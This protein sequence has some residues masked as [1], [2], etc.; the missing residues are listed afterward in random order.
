M[1]DREYVFSILVWVILIACAVGVAFLTVPISSR[2]RVA[3]TTLGFMIPLSMLGFVDGVSKQLG[4]VPC[5][6][7]VVL[8]AVIFGSFLVAFDSRSVS[9]LASADTLKQ[10][11]EHP[12]LED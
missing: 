10:A 1:V 8:M 5:S 7:G 6:G 2:R 11:T 9:K 12:K 3:Y 4:L